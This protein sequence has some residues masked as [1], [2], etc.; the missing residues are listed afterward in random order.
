[1]SIPKIAPYVIPQPQELPVIRLKVAFDPKRAALLIHDMQD[2]FLDFFGP[3]NTTLDSVVQ[4]IVRLRAACES[5]GIPVV[6]T[7]QPAQ[8]SPAER[9]L[10]QDMWG[11][12][13]TAHPNRA[14]I[15]EVL[16]PRDGDTVL[17]KFRY[18][19]FARTPLLSWL[20]AHN[21]TQLIVCGVY[22][23]IGCQC[24]A[25]EAFMSDVVPLMVSDGVADFSRQ[26]HLNALTYVANRCGLVTDT[27]R[28]L[29]QI[30][31][32]PSA[33]NEG[34]G[35]K[36]LLREDIASILEVSEHTLSD[37]T[38]L[39]DAGLDSVR[40]LTL[41]EQWRGKGYTAE[42]MELAETPTLAAWANKLGSDQRA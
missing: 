17:S 20:D 13:I 11:P 38:N 10:L 42:L 29:K 40:V 8:Q 16:R 7:T 23:H 2:Y 22:A 37:D 1:M 36:D 15:R 4:N 33:S 3:A 21:R 41:L 9:G 35:L 6:Y 18:S 14:S 31:Q 26:E 39:F 12:G 30:L 32:S 25:M 27:E 24:T 28:L 19:A 34:E 5:Q